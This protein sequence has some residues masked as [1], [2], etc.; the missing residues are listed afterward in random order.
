MV[1]FGDG[2]DLSTHGTGQL[3]QSKVT[4]KRLDEFQDVRC[5]QLP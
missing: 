1:K 4:R 5:K 3:E 2:R